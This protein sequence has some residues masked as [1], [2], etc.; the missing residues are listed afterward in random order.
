MSVDSR[1][2]VIHTYSGYENKVAANI[3]KIVENRRMGDQILEVRI[4]TEK[5]TEIV[6]DKKREVERKLFPGYVLVKVAVTFDEKDN[7]SMSDDAWFVIRNTRGVTGFVGP[8][9]KAIPLSD[10]EVL[11]L[12]VEKRS[13][14]VNYKVGDMV[15]IIDE[16]FDGFT[17]KVEEI[18]VDK[19]LVRVTVSALFGKETMVELELDQVEPISD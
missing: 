5:V 17:G 2:Y 14:E 4:P 11:K 3:E 6:G 13:V 15:N 12:G 9:S 8:D 16:I 7:P 18:D 1:W 19:N 10:E